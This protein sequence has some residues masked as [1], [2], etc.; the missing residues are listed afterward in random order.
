[1][2]ATHPLCPKRVLL[3]TASNNAYTRGVIAGVAAVA[4]L[5][6]WHVSLLLIVPIDAIPFE[7]FDGVL[8]TTSAGSPALEASGLPAVM[9]SGA[10]KRPGLPCVISDNSAIGRLAAEHLL[11][12]GLSEFVCFGPGEIAM[13]TER[14]KSFSATVQAAGAR[15]RIFD[16]MDFLSHRQLWLHGSARAGEMIDTV[17]KPA[18]VFA[19]TDELAQGLVGM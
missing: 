2:N 6:S 19:V 13:S 12:R 16:Q 3:L 7:A 10:R 11:E 4:R 5:Q 9:C 14:M 18:G 17:P 15:C 8:S 1:M